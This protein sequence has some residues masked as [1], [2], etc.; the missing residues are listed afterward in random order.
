MY[1]YGDNNSNC[2]CYYNYYSNIITLFL[3]CFC[4]CFACQCVRFL[5]TKIKLTGSPKK[6][7]HAFH[8]QVLFYL[9]LNN[10]N[11]NNNN[12]KLEKNATYFSKCAKFSRK[13]N[14][15]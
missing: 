11:N 10:N 5:Q 8:Y 13:R 3:F 4:F 15:K 14:R 12:N 9:K 2:T 6:N 7:I 1:V